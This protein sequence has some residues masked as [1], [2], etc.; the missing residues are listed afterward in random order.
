MGKKCKA[1]A[2]MSRGTEWFSD[3]MSTITWARHD[4]DVE[5]EITWELSVGELWCVRY[6]FVFYLM[7]L[8]T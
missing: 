3:P 4:V 8:N 7:N 1:Y 5:L 6:V 2:R